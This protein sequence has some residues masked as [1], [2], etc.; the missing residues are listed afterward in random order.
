MGWVFDPISMY[1]PLVYF[2]PLVCFR[3][4]QRSIA[5]PP[6]AALSDRFAASSPRGGAKFYVG[7]KGIGWCISRT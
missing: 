3:F 4:R 7:A 1:D 5:L 2:Y 6:G